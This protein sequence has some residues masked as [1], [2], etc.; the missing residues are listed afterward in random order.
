MELF[1]LVSGQI[2]F[3]FD[4]V[5][6]PDMA[7]ISTWSVSVAQVKSHHSPLLEMKVTRNI[8]FGIIA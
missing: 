8:Q 5:M 2:S 4:Y 3:L 6:A 1:L 7:G